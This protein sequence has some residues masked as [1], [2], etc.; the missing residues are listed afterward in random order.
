MLQTRQPRSGGA[1]PAGCS[2]LRNGG[3]PSPDPSG[4]RL[5]PSAPALVRDSLPHTHRYART[6][7]S[8][9]PVEP[10]LSTTGH[11]TDARELTSEEIPAAAG[12]CEVRGRAPTRRRRR[13]ATA[14]TKAAVERSRSAPALRWQISP[15]G[16][17]QRRS[18]GCCHRHV[19]YGHWESGALTR[20][21][22]LHKVPLFPDL[23]C[24]GAPAAIASSTER[25]LSHGSPV[26][27]WHGG[28]RIL[29]LMLRVPFTGGVR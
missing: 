29:E 27:R 18:P 25:N 8:V 17:E 20:I 26:A 21:R 14:P 11:Y 15:P 24:A 5:P 10:A 2:V 9:V 12:R 28:S 3:T 16:H 1:P 19:V 22:M 23:G 13:P 4:G 6:E 7:V